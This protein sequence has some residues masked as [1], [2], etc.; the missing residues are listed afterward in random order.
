MRATRWLWCMLLIG[1]GLVA[2]ASGQQA[3]RWQVSLDTAK[4][5]AAQSNR[6]VLVHF[7]AD[8][9]QPCREM[10]QQVF[11]QSEVASA[12]ESAFVP[13]RINV[14]HFPRT[15]EQ[16]GVTVLPTE[17]IITP[18]GQL[19]RKIGGVSD[20]RQYVAW[21]NEVAAV[22]NQPR[23]PADQTAS[24]AGAAPNMRGSGPLYYGTPASHPPQYPPSGPAAYADPRYAGQLDP[25]EEAGLS[26]VGPR[27][28]GAALGG[29]PRGVP[30]VTIPASPARNDF[31][32][33]GPTSIAPA[34][35]SA[36]PSTQ[37]ALTPPGWGSPEP[38]SQVPGPASP[39]SMPQ[40]AAPTIQLPPG[41]PP[42]GLDGYC[43]IELTERKQWV[44]GDPRWGL[45]H[46]G[47]TY[48][49][50]G[51]EQ[52]DRF[53]AD[54]DRYAPVASGNDV[55]LLVER[56]ELAPG[57]REHGGWFEDRVYL[58]SGEETYL[59][60]HAAPEQYV[61]TLAEMSRRGSMAR[62]PSGS[63]ELNRSATWPAPRDL[64]RGWR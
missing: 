21:L 11:S 12:V 28:A 46:R 38:Q 47:R 25:Q 13:V 48:L 24:R 53:D 4:R 5:L 17:V 56:G 57:R 55:V 23:A 22:V 64:S 34:M 42:L 61:A 54:P 15:R 14:D 51:P 32:R 40:S 20:A 1:C 26:V 3:V 49:F 18:E 29:P 63:V 50:A 19:V 8:W 30:S 59:K 60:F 35:P 9:C 52:R 45:I 58:F 16:F 43:P 10:E 44:L 37:A 6:L 41:N 62:R 2:S 39:L 27:Y 36:S 31:P 33:G 7:W